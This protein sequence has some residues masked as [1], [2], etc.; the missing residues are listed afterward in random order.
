[1]YF[2]I[3]LLPRILQYCR[4]IAQ[5]SV[6]PFSI[7]HM[8]RIFLFTAFFAV[9]H[10]RAQEVVNI[11]LVGPNGITEDIKQAES[12]IVVKQFP[13]YF[14]RIDY[15]K[16]GPRIRSRCYKDSSLSILEGSFVQ[17]RQDGGILATGNYKDNKKN[18]HWRTYDDT[19]KL[20]SFLK[21]ENDLPVETIDITKKDS[22]KTYPDEKESD[23]PGGQ[24]AWRKYIVKSLERNEAAKSSTGGVVIVDFI[25]GLNGEVLGASIQKSVEFGPDEAVLELVR[26]SPK[27]IPAWQNGHTVKSYKRQEITIGASE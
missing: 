19:G 20:V 4:Y 2:T 7:K 5:W 27:W 18:D 22:V 3:L 24:K 16:G 26:K 13:T 12:F 25:I 6:T 15:K 11:V 14:E 21:Y 17:Y 1:M 23:F 9:T 8:K 10:L